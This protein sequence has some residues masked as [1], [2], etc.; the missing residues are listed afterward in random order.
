MRIAID[1][2]PFFFSIKTGIYRYTWSLFKALAEI[3]KENEYNILV[4]DNKIDG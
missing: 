4:P 2:L 3:D 1:G